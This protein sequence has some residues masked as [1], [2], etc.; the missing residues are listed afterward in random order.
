M[1]AALVGLAGL[2][3]PVVADPALADGRPTALPAPR[4]AY[5]GPESPAVSAAPGPAPAAVPAFGVLG[6]TAVAKPTPRPT[7]PPSVAGPVA[8][9]SSRTAVASRSKPRIS[10]T[11]TSGLT[12]GARVVLAS[13]TWAF[14][15]ITSVIGVRPDSLPDH[16]TGHAID[17]MIPSP[18]SGSG[19]A[20]GNDVVA[21]V[22]ANA[23]AW[24]VKYLIYRQRI[25]T[26]GSGWRAMSDRGSPTANHMDHVHVTVT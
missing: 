4:T 17:F 26:P 22:Q 2:A 8:G 9:R 5:A 19:S 1:T 6:F 20:L 7:R 3:F 24:H 11:G 12:S 14:P 15:Q 16:P 21:A 18:F 10:G 25:W 23:G 13:V